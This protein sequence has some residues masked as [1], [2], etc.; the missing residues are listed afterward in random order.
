VTEHRRH[1]T[2]ASV[3]ESPDRS[4]EEELEEGEAVAV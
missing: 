1:A 3:V 2:T 4:R